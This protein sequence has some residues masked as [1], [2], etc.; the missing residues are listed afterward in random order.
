MYKP[1]K[2]IS[3]PLLDTARTKVMS[4]NTHSDVTSS[5]EFISLQSRPDIRSLIGFAR[6]YSPYYGALYSNVPRNVSSLQD[7]PVIDL[8][9]F[10]RANT[11]QKSQVITMPHSGGIV[12]KTGGEKSSSKRIT[13]GSVTDELPFNVQE[14]SAVP[15]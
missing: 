15:K 13:H 5:T 2:D 1:V 11:C 4:D 9:S 3:P 8:D 14:P 10:W 6:T 12:W 7:Y